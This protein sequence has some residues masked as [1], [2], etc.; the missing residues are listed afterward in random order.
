MDIIINK[1]K[2]SGEITAP[3][4]KS[5]AHRYI[6]CAALSEGVSRI[7]NVDLSED[8]KA[9]IDCINALGAKATIEE[10]V[11]IVEGINPK[12]IRDNVEDLSQ[13]IDFLCRE[14]GSTMR[15]FMGLSMYLG[16]S[17]RFYGSETLRNRP[18][19]IY[20]EIC[21][22]QGIKFERLSDHIAINGKL[23]A[24][25]YNIK[26]NI[27]SQFI[28][29]L[30]FSL[31]LLEDDS[32]INLIPPVESRSYINLTIQ[33]L[34]LFGV[35][36]KWNG[37][38]QI[39]IKGGQC[40]K[41]CDTLVEGDCSNA[42]FL[43]AF[44]Y[45]GGDVSVL[46]INKDTLQGDA[47]YKELFDELSN[48]KDGSAVIDISD[49]PDLG[50]VLFAVAACLNGAKFIGTKRLK[51]KES[52]RG[53]VMCAE[54][55]KLSIGSSIEENEITISAGRLLENR[56]KPSEDFDGHNDHRI[57]M[58]MAIIASLTGGRI[59]GAQAVAKSYPGFFDD[60]EK[61]GINIVK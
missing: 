15:F 11:V 42:A 12:K 6:I 32:V 21:N 24:G 36:T 13:T 58:S 54:L 57:V 19:G 56:Y 45:I 3:P 9:T 8:I 4:S 31:P 39:V 28:T 37:D 47:V 27:S 23:S 44:N 20:E 26:G 33:A 14:S 41:A 38:C 60:I 17:S 30:M 50:P 55:R 7:G 18:F 1:S 29:G 40:Y 22:N 53:T 51:I 10:D 46:G 59:N 48:K 61:L 5:L 52:D 34:N 49:C 16:K 35:S 25:S 43:E 2:A